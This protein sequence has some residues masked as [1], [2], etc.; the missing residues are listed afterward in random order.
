MFSGG[1]LTGWW[2][3]WIHSRSRPFNMR[4]KINWPALYIGAG[5]QPCASLLSSYHQQLEWGEVDGS[6]EQLSP[7]QH[8]VWELKLSTSLQSA[9]WRGSTRFT[10]YIS[11]ISAPLLH[12]F[13]HLL[14]LIPGNSQWNLYFIRDKI[15]ISRQDGSSIIHTRWFNQQSDPGHA[16]IQ[17]A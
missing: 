8:R 5:Q 14:T 4:N 7:H 10:L 13:N 12:L 6:S 17:S 1:R 2:M 15:R 9:C 16:L 3:L 11:N